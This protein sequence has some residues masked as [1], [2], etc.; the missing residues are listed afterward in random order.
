MGKR[1]SKTTTANDFATT[2]TTNTITTASVSNTAVAVV[3]TDNNVEHVTPTANDIVIATKDAIKKHLKSLDDAVKTYKKGF[4]AIGFNLLWFKDTLAYQQID[5]KEYKNIESFAKDRY[6]IS[7][8]TALGYIQI[9]ERFGQVNPKTN[10]IDSLKDNFKDY[11]PTALMF[12]CTLD[13]E[14]IAKLNP[15]MRVKDIKALA[16]A[17]DEDDEDNDGDDAKSKSSGNSCEDDENDNDDGDDE[18]DNNDDIN[19]DS[20]LSGVCLLHINTVEELENKKEYIFDVM[21]KILTQKTAV[22]Y[23]VG[24]LQLEPPE[25]A[26]QA[27]GGR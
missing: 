2:T 6:D 24:I 25:L 1:M 7:R 27:S 8:S 26:K 23:T 5:G 17:K 11:S 10:E 4:L 19:A 18:N 9:A 14:T 15:N 16:T 3:G 20:R 21:K 22:D 12:M 13:D